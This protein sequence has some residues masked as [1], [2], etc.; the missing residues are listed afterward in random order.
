MRR[1]GKLLIGLVGLTSCVITPGAAS[2]QS[3]ALAH[4]ASAPSARAGYVYTCGD[5]G[6]V[7]KVSPSGSAAA[8]LTYPYPLGQ[9]NSIAVDPSGS[10]YAGLRNTSGIMKFAADGSH[11]KIETGYWSDTVAADSVGD[12]YVGAVT[13]PDQTG[14]VIKVAPDGSQSVIT[15]GIVGGGGGAAAIAVDQNGTIYLVGIEINDFADGYKLFKITPDGVRT[16]LEGGRSSTF[17]NITTVA[18]DN[19]G[20]VYFATNQVVKLAPSGALTT[21]YNGNV[22]AWFHLTNDSQGNVYFQ[23]SA[24]V[25]DIVKIAPSGAETTIPAPQKSCLGGLAVGPNAGISVVGAPTAATVGQEYS[26]S[27]QLR[28]LPL[29][30]TQVAAGALPPGLALSQGGTISGTPTQPGVYKLT[31]SVSNGVDTAITKNV[32]IRV[33]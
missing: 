18:V 12:I 1:C 32:T 10:I 9:F 25:S 6:G 21:V 20:N 8:F 17:Q 26:Y 7:Q 23:N 13:K 28:G 31:M 14:A 16:V 11:T 29:P 3:A 5:G 22:N 2:A 27:F 19:T 4:A 33:S 30:V 15:T 24:P